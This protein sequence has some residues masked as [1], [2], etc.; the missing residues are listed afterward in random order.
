MQKFSYDGNEY[1][2]GFLE[3]SI[4]EGG[5]S[6]RDDAIYAMLEPNIYT[7]SDS[8]YQPVS[9][10]L[11]T[12]LQT[13]L[14]GI[15][16]KWYVEKSSEDTEAPV[17]YFCTNETTDPS[18]YYWRFSDENLGIW[19]LTATA[20][21]VG[22]TSVAKYGHYKSAEIITTYVDSAEA[23]QRAM[24]TLA[25]DSIA[26]FDNTTYIYKLTADFEGYVT[27][28][29]RIKDIEI[30]GNAGNGNNNRIKW[31][32]GICTGE[33][34]DERNRPFVQN[35]N[36]VSGTTGSG[37]AIYGTRSVNVQFC[38]FTGFDSAIDLK[39][40]AYVS[41]CVFNGN[42][43]GVYVEEISSLH[44]DACTFE[45]NHTGLWLKDL[46]KTAILNNYV[47]KWNSFKNNTIAVK[48]NWG[49]ANRPFFMPYN[50]F[51]G[52]QTQSSGKIYT[53]PESVDEF[54][55]DFKW[56]NGGSVANEGDYSIPVSVLTQKT[57]FNVLDSVSEELVGRWNFGGDNE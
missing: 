40:P 10:K 27:I 50:Y 30:D 26:D 52:N 19:Y 9:G 57:S 8:R 28:P 56:E 25:G 34:A 5:Y 3:D 16:M 55:R 14:G 2:F 54:Y 12:D 43:T 36:F 11:R 7:F 38:S 18:E 4:V 6:G 13:Y 46:P 1:Y 15:T 21:K 41:A 42:K 35:I 32:G 44:I 17:H 33:T 37:S 20:S 51:N 29:A 49:N 45:E 39:G 47:I 22:L 53:Y 48:C 24:N 23:L 31:T